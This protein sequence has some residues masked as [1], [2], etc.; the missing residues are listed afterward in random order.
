[1]CLFRHFVPCI[2]LDEG[3]SGAAQHRLVSP[4][5]SQEGSVDLSSASEDNSVNPASFTIS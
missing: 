2:F 3:L 1:V 5:S 4:W